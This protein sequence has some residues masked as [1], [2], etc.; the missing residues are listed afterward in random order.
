MVEKIDLKNLFRSVCEPFCIPIFNGGGWSDLNC[1]AA[2]MSRFQIWEGKGKQ[3]VLLSC[4][5]LDPGGVRITEHIRSNLADL[6]RAVG[7]SPD[8]LTIDRFGIND[9]FIRRHRVPWI[10]NLHTSRGNFPLDDPRHPD[11]SKQYVQDYLKRYGARKVE[12]TALVL[13]RLV[14]H[15]RALC[16]RAILKYLPADA[17][18]QYQSSLELPRQEMSAEIWR[19]LK[20]VR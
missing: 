8:N 17:P 9:D 1:R 2:M 16:L 15:A 3:C 19:L 20:A 14:R 12:A 13:P 4:G 18:D 6:S 7:W 10:D 5:D 11:H